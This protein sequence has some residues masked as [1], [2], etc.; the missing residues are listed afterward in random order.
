MTPENSDPL[1]EITPDT[2][3]CTDVTEAVIAQAL[4]ASTSES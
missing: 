4:A 2:N 1:M 3:G